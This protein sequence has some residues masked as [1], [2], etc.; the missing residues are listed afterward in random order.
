[1]MEDLLCGRALSATSTASLRK[2][3]VKSHKQVALLSHKEMRFDKKEEW[4]RSEGLV[5]LGRSTGRARVLSLS[6]FEDSR[7]LSYLGRM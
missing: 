5:K 6:S 2:V 7:G 3:S 4:Q 1:M